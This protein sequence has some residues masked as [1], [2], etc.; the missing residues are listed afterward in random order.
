MGENGRLGVLRGREFGLGP[1]SH[2]AGQREA[3]DVV[4][5]RQCVGGQTVGLGQGLA[6]AHDL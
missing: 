3:Q 2:D 1:V 4:S 6:H 5:F